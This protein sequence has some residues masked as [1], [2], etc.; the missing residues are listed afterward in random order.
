VRRGL[1]WRAGIVATACL[2]AWLASRASRQD[3]GERTLPPEPGLAVLR[4]VLGIPSLRL[5]PVT[6]EVS[7]GETVAV[8][9]RLSAD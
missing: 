4:Q 5:D 2:L 1:L 9:C 3:P 6:V 7:G 8:E